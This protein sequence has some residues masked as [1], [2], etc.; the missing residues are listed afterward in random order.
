[1]RRHLISLFLIALSANDGVAQG[2]AAVGLSADDR[3]RLAE[4][5]RIAATLGDSI[6]PGWSRIPLATLLVTDDR[7]YLIRHPRP[8]NDFTRA[9][10]DSLLG[11]DVFTRPRVFAPNLLATFPAVSGVPTIVIGR[12]SATSKTST[13][14]ILTLLHEHFHQLQ[15]TQP[16]YNAGVTAL[17]LTRGDQTGMWM[18]NYA[19]PYDSAAVQ[20]RFTE[21]TAELLRAFDNPTD[22]TTALPAI[23][24]SRD[25]LRAALA[26]DDDR[27]LGFQ[28]WQEGVSRYTELTVARRAA[29]KYVP[30]PAFA[31]LTDYTPLRDAVAGL[32]SEIR[33]SLQ[34]NPLGRLHR[35]AFYAAGA[36]YAQ[37]LQAASASWGATY[38]NTE[39]QLVAKP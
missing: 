2:T 27:Y 16:G 1:M 13:R 10:Y 6:W 34:G 15:M 19:F 7:E 38:W 39:Y 8:S 14:W 20:A 26:A 24:A 5:Y 17:N 3:I 28:M 37:T 12:P 32:E 35:V 30:T 4:A 29:A 33:S 11:S 31:A 22:A 23:I 25:R 9:G 18:L 36:A 21:F